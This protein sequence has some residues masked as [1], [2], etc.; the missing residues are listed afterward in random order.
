MTK[1]LTLFAVLFLLAAP[2][3][4][5]DEVQTTQDPST[6]VEDSETDFGTDSYDEDGCFC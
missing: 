2:A 6:W 1:Y 5:A 4:I 3:V